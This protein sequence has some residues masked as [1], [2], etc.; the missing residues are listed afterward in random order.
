MKDRQ[1]AAGAVR[2]LAAFVMAL[3]LGS[4]SA[5]VAYEQHAADAMPAGG[6]AAKQAQA[7]A[8]AAG[9]QVF[10][11]LAAFEAATQG[12]DIQLETFAG[13]A[14]NAVSPCHE[15]VNHQSGQPGTTLNPPVCYEP[16]TL[17]PGFSLRTNFGSNGPN[18]QV[19]FAFGAT[20]VGLGQ[21]VI[22][23]MAPASVT[24]VDFTGAPSAVAM[25][26]W[27]W[28]AGSPLWFTVYGDDDV[29]LGTTMQAPPNPP[30][31]VFA[32]FVSEVPI[33]RVEVASASGATQMI[34]N[35]RFGGSPG[36]LE[37][38]QPAL[39]FGMVAVGETRTLS[40]E[41]RNAGLT[42]VQPVLVAPAAPFAIVQDGCDQPLAPAATCAVQV[43]VTGGLEQHYATSL[44]A[45]GDGGTD[46]DAAVVALSAEVASPRLQ[47]TAQVVLDAD[48]ASASS[49]PVPATVHNIAAVPVEVTA[50]DAPV[51]PL[52]IVG[53][54]CPAVPFELQPGASC[55]IQFVAGPGSPPAG[56]ALVHSTDPSSPHHI[57][58]VARIGSGIF[59]DGFETN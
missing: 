43:S 56:S 54:S 21:H 7:P 38:L 6:A 33:R 40:A 41:F 34:S 39:A 35:L 32:G 28:Q 1:G 11:T 5:Q 44:Q 51:A 3:P 20:T 36:R 17:I 23:A 16:A 46:A 9:L 48:D 26:A 12:A 52:Q 59:A 22:G 37:A 25:N 24:L 57:L 2:L 4:A 10:T 53:G 55:S 31:A 18:G 15:P 47:V 30:T 42:G 27:D 49:D 19:M 13:R 58:L 14:A 45:Y 50:I 29:V 8:G